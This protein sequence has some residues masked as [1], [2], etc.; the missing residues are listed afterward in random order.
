M[1]NREGLE[2]LV[3]LGLDKEVLVET[4][5]GLFT[6]QNLKRVT[7]P[8]VQALRVSNLTSVVDYIKKNI[9]EIGVK[10][11]I[12]V[13]SPEQ[14]N[15]LSPLNRD[16]ERDEF[17]IAKA[18]LPDNIRYDQF[19]DTERFNIMM[20]SSFDDKGDKPLI[21]KFTGLIRDEAVKQTGD[22]GVS[23]KV[24]IKT[25][26][27]SV[28]E[29]EVPNP[30]ILAPYRTF[31][32]IEQPESKFIFRMQEGP[33]AAIFEADGGMWRNQAMKSIKEYLEENLEECN[34]RVEIIS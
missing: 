7:E 17:M 33:R 18:I 14:V 16:G 6:T 11:L 34:Q 23:Q 30:V 29:A 32:E 2:Y 13:R 9:D 25:G 26:V 20:Q 5:K 19:L 27:A 10:L 4:E 1:I 24:T 8:E 21:L 15:V 22:N 3:G 31:P 12:Q 28:G